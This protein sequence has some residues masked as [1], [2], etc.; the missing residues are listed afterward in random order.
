MNTKER[1]K[2]TEPWTAQ[3]CLLR[4]EAYT[5]TGSTQEAEHVLLTGLKARLDQKCINHH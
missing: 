3:P 2:T 4:K 1:S 5:K